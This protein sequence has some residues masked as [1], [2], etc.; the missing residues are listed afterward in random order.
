MITTK[1]QIAQHTLAA[2][3]FVLV[4]GTLAMIWPMVI[5]VILG[6]FPLLQTFWAVWL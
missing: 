3:M 6:I 4:L 2:M 1:S 5:A